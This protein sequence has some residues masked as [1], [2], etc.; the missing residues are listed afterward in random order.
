MACMPRSNVSVRTFSSVM[1]VPSNSVYITG[2]VCFEWLY[3]GSIS[4]SLLA[5]PLRGY[6]RAGSEVVILGTGT[7]IPAQWTYGTEVKDAL[8]SGLF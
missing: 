1:K 2:H 5:C 7:P 3:I 4:A 6:G 8:D